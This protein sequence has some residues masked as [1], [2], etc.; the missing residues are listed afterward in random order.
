MNESLVYIRWRFVSEF[1]T[2]KNFVRFD[3]PMVQLYTAWS[4]VISGMGSDARC[5][6][7]TPESLSASTAVHKDCPWQGIPCLI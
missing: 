4:G 5:G 1:L 2:F 3:N 6:H 7:A